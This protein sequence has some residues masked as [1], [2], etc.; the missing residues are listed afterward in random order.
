MTTLPVPS[1]RGTQKA[2]A[3]LLAM[4]KAVA[5]R[6][7]K[8]FDPDELRQVTRCATRLGRVPTA[9]LDGLVAEFADSFSAGADLVGSVGCA[10]ELLAEALPRDQ[11][12]DILSDVLGRPNGSVWERV[13]ALP[14]TV[15]GGYLAK[16]HPQTAAF[17]LSKVSTACA[18]A[19]LSR[20]PPALRNEV[21]RRI[22]GLRPVG[23]DVARL[24]E[25]ALQT[26]LLA[27]PAQD[28]K[29]GSNARVAEIINKMER[30]HVDAVMQDLERAR[31]EAAS[32]LR[33]LM[34]DFADIP[35]LS[36]KA[37]LILFEKVAPERVI[38]ALD[39]AEAELRELVLSSLTARTRR[40]VESELSN[41]QSVAARD[42]EKARRAIGET[43]LDLA[44]RGE[45]ELGSDDAA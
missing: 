32:A 29:T 36:V 28:G 34:F 10:E 40:M 38:L 16:E 2:A 39:G 45:I 5:A 1:L 30:A 9:A 37:R 4:D 6:L 21:T 8:R 43:V 35:R 18:A 31:P 44:G 33:S 25:A 13:S 11:V 14:D 41:G 3:L 19:A 42:V 12:S 23:E 7:L 20:L 17:I 15:L 24:V 22:I 26:D 27:G